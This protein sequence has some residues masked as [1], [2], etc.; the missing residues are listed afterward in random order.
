MLLSSASLKII[1]ERKGNG[2]LKSGN[3]F[4]IRMQYVCPAAHLPAEYRH[5]LTPAWILQHAT[6]WVSKLVDKLTRALL[7]V[8]CSRGAS[9]GGKFFSH[10]PGNL[11]SGSTSGEKR[12]FISIGWSSF[13]SLYF[14]CFLH[15]GKVVLLP[16]FWKASIGCKSWW[17]IERVNVGSSSNLQLHKIDFQ[18]RKNVSVFFLY[19]RAH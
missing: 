8:L 13:A 7:I 18:Y 12:V 15:R 17:L 3:L 16:S 11:V 2:V 6:G 9:P 14:A 1:L 4:W 5:V 10:V 19:N